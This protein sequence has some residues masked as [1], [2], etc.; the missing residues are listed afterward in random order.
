MLYKSR[1]KG[2]LGM[3]EARTYGTF[4]V[5]GFFTGGTVELIDPSDTCTFVVKG[6]KLMSYER[7]EKTSEKVSLML[8]DP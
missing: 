2:L 3:W 5:N 4:I 1:W 8:A 7:S 6:R